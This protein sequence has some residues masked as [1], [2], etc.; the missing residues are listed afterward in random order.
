M[1]SPRSVALIA[2]GLRVSQTRHGARNAAPLGFADG[3]RRR[4][5]IAARFHFDESDDIAAPRDN[6][7]LAAGD[8]EPPGE[9]AVAFERQPGGGEP[10]GAQAEPVGATL[11][12]SDF[13]GGVGI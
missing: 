4:V 12:R 3:G 7:D 2:Q 9:N 11:W 10:F 13:A 1:A 8:R 6:V 5:E